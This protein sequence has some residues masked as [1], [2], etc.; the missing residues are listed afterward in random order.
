MMIVVFNDVCVNEECVEAVVLHVEY[1]LYLYD[2]DSS[3]HQV[4]WPGRLISEILCLVG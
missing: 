3:C 2:W 1:Y 4:G